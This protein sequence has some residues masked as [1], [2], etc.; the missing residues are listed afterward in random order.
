MSFSVPCIE[1]NW[2]MYKGVYDFTKLYN[3]IKNWF[4]VYQY[5]F[6]ESKFK[7]KS[8]NIGDELELKLSGDKKVDE[9][10]KYEVVINILNSDSNWIEIEENNK[11]KMVLKGRIRI[12][13]EAN[14]IFDYQGNFNDSP[15]WSKFEKNYLSTNILDM[16]INFK[17]ADELMY[18]AYSLHALVKDILNMDT[19]GNN[20]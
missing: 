8:D 4:G 3:A 6:H 11:K 16:D 7:N 1:S 9:W 17:Y 12:S 2:I 20:Y 13:V 15:F 5:K 18:N 14:A 10:V 19:A